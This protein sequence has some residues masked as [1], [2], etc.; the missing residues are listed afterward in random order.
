MGP[1]GGAGLPM[2]TGA[3]LWLFPQEAGQAAGV[4]VCCPLPGTEREPGQRGHMQPCAC[5]RAAPIRARTLQWEGVGRHGRGRLATMEGRA[6]C[7]QAPACARA[8]PRGPGKAQGSEAAS[9]RGPGRLCRADQSW[10]GCRRPS[11]EGAAGRQTGA[12]H[13]HCTLL[14]SDT[15]HR[16]HPRA[17]TSMVPCHTGTLTHAW[18]THSPGSGSGVTAAA[19]HSVCRVSRPHGASGFGQARGASLEDRGQLQS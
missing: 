1:E 6:A 17:L 7:R 2:C 5:G 12:L 16:P 15:H 3:G 8:C 10:R 13:G 19:S 14:G 9:L 18:G 4:A 11:R